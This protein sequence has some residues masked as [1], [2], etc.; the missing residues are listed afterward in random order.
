MFWGEHWPVT[1]RWHWNVNY[2]NHNTR[3]SSNIV[4]IDKSKSPAFYTVRCRQIESGKQ[5]YWN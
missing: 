2:C 4:Y 1:N 3:D 5:I